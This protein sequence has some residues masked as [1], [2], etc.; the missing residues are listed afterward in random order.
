MVGYHMDLSPRTWI[1]RK[2]L[3]SI[4]WKIGCH[5]KKCS[6]DTATSSFPSIFMLPIYSDIILTSIPKSLS[7]AFCS[8][9]EFTPLRIALRYVKARHQEAEYHSHWDHRKGGGRI[10]GGQKK[11]L[12]FSDFFEPFWLLFRW[13]CKKVKHRRM[14]SDV[15]QS[16]KYPEVFSQP[17]DLTCYNSQP[18]F[19]AGWVVHPQN[20]TAAT[21][22]SKIAMGPL[23]IPK[24]VLCKYDLNSFVRPFFS[25]FSKERSSI[26]SF[27]EWKRKES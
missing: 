8:Q 19:L 13:Q 9:E 4:D 1:L 6:K 14:D 23:L 20:V 5:M 25:C 17:S 15:H 3:Q 10:S 21:K 2:T 24:N 12:G 18:C 16:L 11:P 7:E 27:K 22:S 26:G